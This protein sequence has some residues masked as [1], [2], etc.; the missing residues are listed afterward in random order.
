MASVDSARRKR[1]RD[2]AEQTK[3]SRSVQPSPK[4][5]L[6]IARLAFSPAW[7]TPKDSSAQATPLTD[8]DE[9]RILQRFKMIQYAKNTIGYQ[10]YIRKV[11]RC[12][13]FNV[14]CILMVRSLSKIEGLVSG[15]NDCGG[16]R[17]MTARG[18][19]H[20]RYSLS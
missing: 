13:S 17:P 3:P 6:E 4:S 16:E 1:G 5:A 20:T 15:L 11:P 9:H 10:E 19:G 7:G 12:V 18:D 14:F 2:E 8:Q